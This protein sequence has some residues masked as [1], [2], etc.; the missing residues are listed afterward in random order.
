MALV[1]APEHPLA[2]HPSVSL[3]DLDGLPFIGFADDIP[4]RKLVDDRLRAAGVRVRA[5]T[6]FDNIET[7]K[8]LVE[9]GSGVSILPA[10]TVRQEVGSGISRRRPLRPRRR[11]PPSYGVA[12]QKDPDPPGGGAGLC[13]GD[14]G[15]TLLGRIPGPGRALA[16]TGNRARTQIISMATASTMTRTPSPSRT[17]K[18]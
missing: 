11:L 3:C 4:T 18:L 7:I 2:Q 17:A 8:N 10:D 13:G 16:N 15:R 5:I 9:I 12:G 14:A 6:S 1:C